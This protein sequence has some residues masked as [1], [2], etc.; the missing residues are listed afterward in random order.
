MPDLLDAINVISASRDYEP[1]K[2][3]GLF[4]NR[5]DER[6]QASRIS[7]QQL[8][9]Y[10]DTVDGV[11]LCVNSIPNTTEFEKAAL[12]SMPATHCPE[13]RRAGEAFKS[14]FAELYSDYAE[15]SNVA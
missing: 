4:L 3:R 6:T 8:D 5:Y 10:L 15:A 12:L 13:S 1:L 11:G 2:L 14:V 7:R 9:E